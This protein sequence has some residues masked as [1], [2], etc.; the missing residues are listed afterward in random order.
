MGLGGAAFPTFRKLTLPAGVTVD[1][2][3]SAVEAMGGLKMDFLVIN[4]LNDIAAAIKMKKALTKSDDKDKKDEKKGGDEV[5]LDDYL[6]ALSVLDSE[7]ASKARP[8]EDFRSQI[9]YYRK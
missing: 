7:A 3:A 9:A 8:K 1:T 4:S 2:L 6:Q 5:T